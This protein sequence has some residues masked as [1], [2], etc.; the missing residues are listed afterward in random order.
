MR[1]DPEKKKNKK[2]KYVKEKKYN[3]YNTLLHTG[4]G[5]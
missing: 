3:V 1:T 2:A 4:A 5:M